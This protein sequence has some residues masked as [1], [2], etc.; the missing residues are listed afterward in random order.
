VAES[1]KSSKASRPLGQGRWSELDAG[2]A[3]APSSARWLDESC[4]FKLLPPREGPSVIGL[5]NVAPP[6]SARIKGNQWLRELGT[7]VRFGQVSIE[8]A[9]LTACIYGERRGGPR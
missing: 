5:L 6:A 9:L 3:S 4:D 1:F 2:E 8:R 7:R